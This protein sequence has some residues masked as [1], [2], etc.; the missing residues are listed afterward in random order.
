MKK[1]AIKSKIGT[2]QYSSCSSNND[3]AGS[4]AYRALLGSD[5]FILR[6]TNRPSASF[7]YTER[8]LK[9]VW[10][11]ASLRPGILH[12]REGDAVV[13]EHPGRWNLEPGPDFLGAALRIDACQA[14]HDSG[15]LPSLRNAGRPPM[16]QRVTGDVEI[17]ITA[18][19]WKRHGH[20]G[21]PEYGRVRAHVTYFP[22]Y[23]SSCSLPSG[24]IQISLKETLLS[25]PRFSFEAIDLTA[26]PFSIHAHT[27]PCSRIMAAGG[28]DRAGAL[29]DAAGL[30]RMRLKRER[31]AAAALER[32]PDQTLYEEIMTA[33]GYKKNRSPFRYLAE[34]MPLDVLREESHGDATAAYALLTGLAG[35]LPAQM[36]AWWDDETR[37][38]VRH[39]WDYW[40]KHSARWQNRA[41][42]R[43]A[44]NMSGV[45]PQNHPKRRLM[46]AALLFCGSMNLAREITE[47]PMDNTKAWIEKMEMLLRPSSESSCYWASRLSFS[48]PR[49]PRPVSLTGSARAAAIIS[50][51]V[52]PFLAI[53]RQE[54]PS[55]ELLSLLAPE[56]N[57]S[58]A[59]QTANALL[60]P[61]HNPSLYRT[62]L[63][64]QGLIQIFHD[65]CLNDRS[66]CSN[67]PLPGM[68]KN[69]S[70]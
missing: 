58:I 46:T 40:W 1:A 55:M 12:T 39:L 16:T 5:R 35:L 63:R 37:A 11:D 29:L 8:H 26:Y 49:Q 65:F 34:Q 15:V 48:G 24:T 51:V 60:G 31:F 21:N 3:F 59:R 62:G 45:R 7:P 2:I 18:S 6:E 64:Q 27:T 50:N 41:L 10:F 28:A 47:T 13:I 38:F 68:L 42:D 52:I 67:C 57:N 56:E 61:D 36:S 33:L 17:H 23:L 14:Q 44:W 53:I 69:F 19:D 9:C 66:G 43:A 20:S 32:G 25:N 54:A 22:G 4:E 70:G 30:E